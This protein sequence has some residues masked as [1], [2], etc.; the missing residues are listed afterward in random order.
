[1]GHFERFHRF[2]TRAEAC[3]K[4]V[5]E[6]VRTSNLS[7][8]LPFAITLQ[9]TRNKLR[10]SRKQLSH[11]AGLSFE[12]T[13][14]A[15][16]RC[17]CPEPFSAQSGFALMASS[18]EAGVLMSA[19]LTAVL[20]VTPR[21]SSPVCASLSA[22]FRSVRCRLHPVCLTADP[23]FFSDSSRPKYSQSLSL[24]SARVLGGCHWTAE[25]AEQD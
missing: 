15:V 23:V 18:H 10:T 5:R 1:M 13:I 21:A 12:P 7:V 20:G 22:S 25:S 6:I 9:Q 19:K 2:N 16:T 17:L 8:S 11:A 14:R 4:L 3:S 24:V